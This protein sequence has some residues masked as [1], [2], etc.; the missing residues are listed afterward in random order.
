[1]D[2][3]YESR[4]SNKAHWEDSKL[5]EENKGCYYS[6]YDSDFDSEAGMMDHGEGMEVQGPVVDGEVGDRT[7]KRGSLSPISLPPVN[8]DLER[9]LHLLDWECDPPP[10]NWSMEDALEMLNEVQQ[11]QNSK[12]TDQ[13]TTLQYIHGHPPTDS[14][15]QTDRAQLCSTADGESSVQDMEVDVD[16]D[17][18]VGSLTFR[19]SNYPAF[20]K[21]N[22]LVEACVQIE[23]ED[24]AKRMAEH[25]EREKVDWEEAVRLTVC[26]RECMFKTEQKERVRELEAKIRELENREEIRKIELRVASFE[27]AICSN[28]TKQTMTDL[29]IQRCELIIE[30]DRVIGLES[31]VAS[32]KRQI[33]VKDIEIKFLRGQVEEWKEDYERHVEKDKR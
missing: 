5:E 30:R 31:I 3:G 6:L 15:E 18:E 24:L 9:E 26:I 33:Q 4:S 1:M 22:T 2:T 25:R 14:S 32:L 28:M 21:W 8:E 7:P 13:G 27:K 11:A 16:T 19:D 23:D 20:L 17:K 10:P 12:S 29:D